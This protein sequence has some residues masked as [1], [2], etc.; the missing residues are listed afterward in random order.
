MYD[1]SENDPIDQRADEPDESI[2]PFVAWMGRITVNSPTIGKGGKVVLGRQT[3][4]SGKDQRYRNGFT[5]S[6]WLGVKFLTALSQ[7]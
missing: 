2:Q 6:F 7:T 5:S 4:E 1:W 3:I